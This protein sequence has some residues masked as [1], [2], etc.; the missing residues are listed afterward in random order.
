MFNRRYF[1]CLVLGLA[2][3]ARL[4]AWPGIEWS[5]APNE[6]QSGQ[7][8]YIEVHAWDEDGYLGPI[9]VWRQWSPFTY[10]GNAG[11]WYND[12]RGNWAYD[13]GEQWIEYEAECEDIWGYSSGTIYHSIHILTPGPV[14]QPAVTSSAASIFVNDSFTP[15]YSGGAGTGAYQFCVVGYTNWD[16]AG[17]T[18]SSAG[19]YTFRVR[20]LGDSNYLDSD[21]SDLY[22][23]TVMPLPMTPP[24][25]SDVTIYM[26]TVTSWSPSIYAPPENGN[27]TLMFCVIGYTN[28]GTESWVPI[29]AGTYGVYVGQIAD[30]NHQGNVID[31]IQGPMEVNTSAYTLTVNP[32]PA[33]FTFSGGPFTYDGGA[34]SVA[35]STDPS[36]ATYSPSGTWSATEAGT[37]T[38][39]ATAYGSYTGSASYTW[40]IDKS[41]QDGVGVSP[42]SQT[43][44]VG[45]SINFSASGSSGTGAYIWGGAAS[46]SGS[47]NNVTFYTAGTWTVTVYRQGDNNYY[48]SNTATATVTVNNPVY[49]LTVQSGS[50]SVSGMTEGSPVS[51]TA[52]APPSGQVFSDWTLVSGPGAFADVYASSTTFMMGAGNATV[53][54]NYQSTPPVITSVLTASGTVDAAFSYTIT[55][56]NS[57]TSYGASGLPPDL[58]INT[59]TGGI[60]G[61]PTAAGTYNVG[62]GATNSGGNDTATLVITVNKAD[63]T[64]NFVNPGQHTLGD[65]SF[66]LSATATSGL[67]VSYAIVSGPA[68]VFGQYG[69]PHW[70]GYCDDHCLSSWQYQL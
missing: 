40:T 48:D 8:Y 38:A 65:A 1:S 34:K 53:M 20:R 42:A 57:P 30:S 66:T 45:D 29:Q 46:G 15:S 62:L 50:G 64:L 47:T 26:G 6:S 4:A 49:S 36:G 12:W 19:T 52:D 70:R 56:T 28:W 23:L 5:S 31:T 16:T 35:V 18:A 32:G 61:T 51:I 21:P 58:S 22:T 43:I 69:D 55:A 2:A 14:A 41:P 27:G 11:D 37:Y 44:T 68:T 3:A 59:T 33:N 54:A 67:S 63:Q 13:T 10:F 39:M 17:W 9:R 60:S 25:S 24:T 7:G